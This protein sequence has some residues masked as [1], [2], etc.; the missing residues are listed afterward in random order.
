[1]KE[2]QAFEKAPGPVCSEEEKDKE[3][4]RLHVSVQEAW[5]NFL[6]YTS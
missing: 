3:G 6:P 2:L 5:G 4:I 1:V